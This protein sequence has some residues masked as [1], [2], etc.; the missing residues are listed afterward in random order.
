[1]LAHAVIVHDSSKQAGVSQDEMTM[2]DIY[3]GQ[4]IFSFS[5]ELLNLL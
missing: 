2:C 5:L 3:K 1:M 4:C